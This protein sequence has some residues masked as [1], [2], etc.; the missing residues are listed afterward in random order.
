MSSGL[1]DPSRLERFSAGERFA[2]DPNAIEREL[3]SLWRSAGRS[4]EGSSPVTRACLWNVAVHIEERPGHEGHGSA[5]PLETAIRELPRYLAARALVLRTLPAGTGLPEL[6]SWIA[7]NCI[8]AGGG[9]KLVCSEEVAIAARGDGERHLPGLVRALLVPQLPTAVVFAGVPP[10]GRPTIDGLI[11]AADRIVVYADHSQHPAPLARLLEVIRG[12]PLGAIDLG[13]LELS[14]FR[15]VLGGLFDPPVTEADIS[16]LDR[17]RFSSAPGRRWSSLLV[18]G[19][20]A[21]ALGVSPA[22]QPHPIGHLAWRMPRAGNR[23]LELVLEESETSPWPSVQLT[24]RADPG[25]SYSVRST[26]ADLAELS[27]PHISAKKPLGRVDPP[28]LLARALRT[29]SEDQAFARALV[30][31]GRW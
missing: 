4:V 17:V 27:G 6:E 9:G 18:L 23:A 15:S 22:D 2:V 25:L 14:P 21:S 10:G 8:V 11:Q 3:A 29:R 12:S 19:W 24:S 26:G 1:A 20:I 5:A 28:Q 31:A 7:A 16:R 13:W 30:L